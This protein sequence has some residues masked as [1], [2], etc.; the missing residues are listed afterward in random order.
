M[1]IFHHIWL[2]TKTKE[3][4]LVNESDIADFVKKK[5]NINKKLASNKRKHVE[6]Q[7]KLKEFSGKVKVLLT[8]GYIFCWVKHM[9]MVIKMF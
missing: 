7:K 3:A 1:E 9:K 5:K 8:K 6:V 2:Y 4:T